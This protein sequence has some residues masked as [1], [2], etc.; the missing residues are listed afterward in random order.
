MAQIEVGLTGEVTRR[1]TDDITAHAMGSGGVL[2]LGTP[3]MI[4]LMEQAAMSAHEGRLEPGQTT[5]GT[6]IDVRHLAATPVGM[7]VTVRARIV[8]ID[9]RKLSYEVEAHDAREPVGI[10]RHERFIVDMGRFLKRVD[11][12]STT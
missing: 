7:D 10:G 2:V 11:E 4:M 5:V 8:A 1:V 6:H 9:E 12:K 3:A